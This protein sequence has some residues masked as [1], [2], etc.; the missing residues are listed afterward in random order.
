MAD[1]FQ[2]Q[3]SNYLNKAKSSITIQQN[4]NKL[5]LITY[6]FD[7]VSDDNVNCTSNITDN[8]VENNTAIQDHIALSPITVSL[9]GLC[10]EL[11]YEVEQ[12]EIDYATELAQAE[13]RNS[14]PIEIANF[15]E[16]GSIDD[17]DGKL[18]AIGSFIPQVSNITQKAQNLWNLHQISQKRATKIANILTGKSQRGLS[19]QMNAYSGA[20]TNITQKR[21][22]QIGNDLKICWESR[23]P[24]IVNTPFGDFDN[25]YIQSIALHQGNELYIGDI[26]ITLKQIRYANTLTTKADKEVLA[27]YNQTAQAQEENYGVAG[28]EPSVLFSTFLGDKYAGTGIKQ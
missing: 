7:T 28:G 9:K 1:T 17:V 3:T 21:L 11:V 5:Q 13:W 25:M 27:K 8:W 22:K 20:N 2:T 6:F 4:S 26:D 23:K 15:G 12:A 24:F 19:A 14:I 18:S 10:G 16:W